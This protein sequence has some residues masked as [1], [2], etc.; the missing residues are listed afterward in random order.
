MEDR[1]C[2]LFVEFRLIRS[3]SPRRSQH[4]GSFDCKENLTKKERQMIDPSCPRTRVDF[5]RWEDEDL[6]RWISRVEQYFHYHRITEASMVDIVAIHL[7]REVTQWYDWYKHTHR[8]STWRQFKSG[9][10]LRFGLSKYEN[11]DGQF[12]KLCKTSTV[13]EY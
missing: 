10:L 3:S 13:Q 5:T 9:L 7:G 6:T 2:A 11:I 1:L 4:G 8:V 12:V